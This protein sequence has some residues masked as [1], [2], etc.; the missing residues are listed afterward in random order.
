MAKSLRPCWWNCCSPDDR[1]LLSDRELSAIDAM[2]DAIAPLDSVTAAT[3]GLITN[4][5]VCYHE[6]DKEAERIVRAIATGRRPRR[7]HA[8]PA[9]RKRQLQNTRRILSRWCRNPAVKG[10]DLDVGGVSA[11]RLL[12]LIGEPNPLK[13]WQVRRLIA[14]VNAALDPGSPYHNMALDLGDHGEPAESSPG[15]HYRRQPDF[16]RRTQQTI[17]HDTLDGKDSRV[18]LAMAIDLF[19]PCHWDFVGALTVILGAIGGNLHPDR[20]FACCARNVRLSPLCDRVRT[21]ADTMKVFWK[22][23]KAGPN[24]DRRILQYLSEP[25]PEKRWLAA[26]LYKTI[27]IQLTLPFEIDL[28]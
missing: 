23:R 15:H 22:G 1:R 18:S 12:S 25:T 11:D 10:I 21:I 26:S 6:A 28:V 4:Y 2:E 24:T 27:Q 16:L 14:R 13:T 3:R 20:P 19:M 5:E 7:S 9:Q 8:R 17:I